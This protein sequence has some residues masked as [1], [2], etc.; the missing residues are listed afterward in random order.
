MST[1][2][3]INN[4]QYNVTF[5]S[6][7]RLEIKAI[8]YST[9]KDY[10]AVI[11]IPCIK[12]FRLIDSLEMLYDMFNDGLKHDNDMIKIFYDK[13]KDKIDISLEIKFKYF[14]ETF[15]C[16]LIN[17]KE[18]ESLDILNN[19]MHYFNKRLLDYEK[20]MEKIKTLERKIEEMNNHMN[21]IHMMTEDSQNLLMLPEHFPIHIKTANSLAIANNVFTINNV[22]YNMRDK[23]TAPIDIS[24]P[25]PHT[26]GNWTHTHGMFLPVAPS[27][28]LL[29]EYLNYFNKLAELTSVSVNTNICQHNLLFIEK[30][31]KITTITLTGYTDLHDISVLLKYPNLT[32]VTIRGCPNIKNL[33]ILE[34][35]EKLE[36]L[37]I[38]KSMHTG[39][40]SKNIKFNIINI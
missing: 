19:K 27:P 32:S 23:K 39:C 30:C 17:A 5:K 40:F 37:M 21:K 7:G 1:P 33:Y 15:E 28:I 4:Y 13:I 29:T 31:I 10:V 22:D 38:E 18:A 34:D 3:I 6:D 16:S 25:I 2:I 12:D 26:H 14:V 9:L 11:D 8:D 36:K 35:C 24:I 20:D